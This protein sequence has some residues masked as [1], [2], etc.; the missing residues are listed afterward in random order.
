MAIES[1][2]QGSYQSDLWHMASIQ[3]WWLFC[4]PRVMGW[5]ECTKCLEHWDS[6]TW[7]R[8]PQQC[9][10]WSTPWPGPFQGGQTDW[11][12]SK[13]ALWMFKT[14]SLFRW[15]IELQY[16]RL[17]MWHVIMQPTTTLWWLNLPAMWTTWTL[18]RLTMIPRSTVYGELT[19]VSFVSHS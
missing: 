4:S 15:L 10:P 2:C 9:T 19:I 1:F 17:A 14:I 12:C 6:T 16:T 13:G 5:G 8:S 3:H 18:A 7:V 11:H